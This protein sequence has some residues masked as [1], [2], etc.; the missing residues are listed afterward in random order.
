MHVS[1]FHYVSEHALFYSFAYGG[2][3]DLFDKLCVELK[4]IYY[5]F[6][7]QLGFNF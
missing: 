1:I 5:G 7:A 6:G 3:F 4:G 2:C